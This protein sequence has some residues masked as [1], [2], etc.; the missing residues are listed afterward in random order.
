M[1]A[2]KKWAL[3]S[4]RRL[5]ANMPTGHHANGPPCCWILCSHSFWQHS[6][7]THLHRPPLIQRQ[8]LPNSSHSWQS[9]L[10]CDG[11]GLELRPWTLLPSREPRPWRRRGGCKAMKLRRCRGTLKRHWSHADHGAMDATPWPELGSGHDIGMQKEAGGNNSGG[12]RCT[13]VNLTV[14]WSHFTKFQW[15]TFIFL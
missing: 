7:V 6:A 1:C 11:H 10:P 4:S 13:T 9:L 2:S 3:G 5:E 14:E 12:T 15:F 8:S